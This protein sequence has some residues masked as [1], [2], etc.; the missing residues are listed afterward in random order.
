MSRVR[1]RVG[2]RDM[3][4]FRVSLWLGLVLAFKVRVRMMI[5]VRIP[6]CNR[7]TNKFCVCFSVSY[8]IMKLR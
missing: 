3:L 6:S 2:I 1:I 4:R 7:F 8:H 5:R